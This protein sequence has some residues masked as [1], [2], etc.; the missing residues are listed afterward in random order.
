MVLN[1]GEKKEYTWNP[2]DALDA[3]WYSLPT[4]AINGHLQQ[5]WMKNDYSRSDLKGTFGSH[6]QVSY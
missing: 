1:N 2:G 6:H 4:V 3:N 5:S